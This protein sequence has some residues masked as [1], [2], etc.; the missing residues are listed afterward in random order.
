MEKG[1]TVWLTGLCCS[2]KTTIA[3]KIENLTDYINL[4]GDDLRAKLN[5]D[6]T[7][8]PEDRAENLR[9]IGHIAQLFNEKGL[10][11]ICSFVSPTES[12]RECALKHIDNVYIIYIKCSVEECE[13]R[14][15]KGMYAK[16]RSGEIPM[17]T[18]VSSPYDVPKNPDL[19]LDTENYAL[20]ECVDQ[21]LYFID[22]IME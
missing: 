9:R 13:R 12:L 14:D 17:F 19:V 21:L 1:K 15:V 7:F 22:N 18:G 11:I 5:S 20:D 16:A 10:N 4:D 3:K 8:T 2:G 6:L